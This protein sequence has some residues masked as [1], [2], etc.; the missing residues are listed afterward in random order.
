M[1]KKWKNVYYNRVEEDLTNSLERAGRIDSSSK[2]PGRELKEKRM[3]QD[4]VDLEMR[5]KEQ[6]I[7]L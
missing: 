7:K 6:K 1:K 2:T 4:C 5:L 3:Q